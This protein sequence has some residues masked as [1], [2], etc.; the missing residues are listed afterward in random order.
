VP[1]DASLKASLT[2]GEQNI[3]VKRNGQDNTYRQPAY[4]LTLG[5][6]TIDMQLSAGG[7]LLFSSQETDWDEIGDL[8]AVLNDEFTRISDEL[9]QQINSQIEAQVEMLNGHLEKVTEDFARIGL[10][11]EETETLVRKTRESSAQAAARTQ[12][13]MH[14]AQEK[15]ER[16]LAAAQRKIELKI[17]AVKTHG[18]DHKPHT[19]DFEWKSPAGRRPQAAQDVKPEPVADEERLVILHMLEQK[20]IT[21]EEAE[22]L[23]AALE[24]REG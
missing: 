4:E 20:K 18:H 7:K 1:Q 24:G 22:K 21:L 2:S 13:K 8:D 15:L 19:W 10:S 16:K 14:L 17:N 11:Q 3:R 12:Q 23:L 6:G 9:T 5:D